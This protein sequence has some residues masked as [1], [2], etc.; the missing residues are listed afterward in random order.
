MSYIRHPERVVAFSIVYSTQRHNPSPAIRTIGAFTAVRRNSDDVSFGQHQF[1]YPNQEGSTPLADMASLAN[2]QTDCLGSVI[3]PPSRHALQASGVYD[4]VAARSR[5]LPI[6]ARHCFRRCH[7]LQTNMRTFRGISRQNGI[8]L[9]RPL[10][11]DTMY[12]AYAPE[13]AQAIW[14]NWVTLAL[15]R[16]PDR[17]SLLAAHRAW[18]MIERARVAR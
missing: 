3:L 11:T 10:S 16:D 4:P 5:A 6:P 7:F 1:A 13:R 14:V 2:P 18:N 9:E 12:A 15:V 8:S 17:A